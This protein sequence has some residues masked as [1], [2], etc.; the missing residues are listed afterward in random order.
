MRRGDGKINEVNSLTGVSSFDWM[1]LLSS[2]PRLFRQWGLVGVE[3]ADL[4]C[5]L[6]N[7]S[8]CS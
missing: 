2:W 6:E 3:V 4:L 5:G 7:I 8:V 1:V